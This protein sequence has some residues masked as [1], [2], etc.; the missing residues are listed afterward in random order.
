[1]TND[2]KTNNANIHKRIPFGD[3]EGVWT[4]IY[5]SYSAKHKKATAFIKFGNEEVK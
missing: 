3:I 2:K 5:Y 4:Y 1:M